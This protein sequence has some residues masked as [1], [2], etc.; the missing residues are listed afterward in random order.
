[1]P[2]LVAK[3]TIIGVSSFST[4]TGR[5]MPVLAEK[6]TSI[7]RKCRK[8]ARVTAALGYSYLILYR[9]FFCFYVKF[10][11]YG[12]TATISKHGKWYF[13]YVWFSERCNNVTD[14]QKQNA[15]QA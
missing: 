10:G 8:C 4:D 3:M 11:Q 1:M 14:E 2:V 7:G 13:E 9:R 5:E 15:I 6:N 12:C